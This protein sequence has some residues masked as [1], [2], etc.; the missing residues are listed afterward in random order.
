MLWHV[1]DLICLT[2]SHML[3]SDPMPHGNKSEISKLYA[4]DVLSAMA[5]YEVPNPYWISVADYC[6]NPLLKGDLCPAVACIKGCCDDD[7]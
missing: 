6:L 1:R 7:E 5:R 2:L 4:Y 3:N